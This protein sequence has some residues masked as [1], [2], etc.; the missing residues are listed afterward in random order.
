MDG[1]LLL[2]P[3]LNNFSDVIF[4]NFQVTKEYSDLPAHEQKLHNYYESFEKE[5]LPDVDQLIAGA[6]KY[7]FKF[8]FRRA[9]FLSSELLLLMKF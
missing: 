8:N 9:S 6:K 4:K 2:A 7:Y 3:P 5:G 1:A